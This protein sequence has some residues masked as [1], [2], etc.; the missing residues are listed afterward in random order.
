MSNS[1]K[2]R[3]HGASCSDNKMIV[4]F[5]HFHHVGR[6][7]SP[8]RSYGL[9]DISRVGVQAP[10]VPRL[11]GS[12]DCAIIFPKEIMQY[13]LQTDSAF[14]LSSLNIGSQVVVTQAMK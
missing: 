11:L 2:S 13:S 14:F 7:C 1:A 6:A 3:C 10:A 9:P 8:L 4:P 12:V 5:C